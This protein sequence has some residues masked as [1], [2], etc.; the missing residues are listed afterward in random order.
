[1]K[2][3]NNRLQPTIVLPVLLLAAV[4]T[5]A[6]LS[7]CPVYPTAPLI[8][9]LERLQD[10]ALATLGP[11]DFDPKFYID[12]SLRFGLP[13][14]EKAF[15]SLPRTADGTVPPVDLEGFIGKYFRDPTGDLVV[16]DPPDYV[17]EPEGF[18]PKVKHPEMRAWALEIHALWK[19]LSRAVSG[20]VR[21][22]PDLHTL[23]PLP[24]QFVIPGSRFR[25]V[26][27][28][29]SYWVIRFI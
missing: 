16:V 11:K 19:N 25:E 7:T 26:Y 17:P 1:M 10:T 9:F 27:Y 20:S 22:R 3:L 14:V 21:E 5:T 4:M 18:L 23:L 2:K 29:D 15:D 28:W 6:Y 8:T 24:E 13:E 12:L